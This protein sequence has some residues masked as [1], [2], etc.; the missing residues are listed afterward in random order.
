M[1]KTIRN[2]AAL[3]V[4]AA[5]LLVAGTAAAYT[6]FTSVNNVCPTCTQ[7]KADVLTTNDGATIRGSVLA[8]NSSFYVFF[9][10][11]E[12]R[13]IPKNEVQKIEWANGTKPGGL[14]NF[15]QI[16][17]KS[18]HVM[19]GTIVDNKEKP[20][21][22]QIKSSKGELTYVVFKSQVAKIF[23]SGSESSL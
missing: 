16:V 10:Y 13:A 7:P 18:G 17:L 19:S 6:P 9:R 11:G 5:T 4:F 20:A 14:T 2:T 23:K 22:F 15:D 1:V 12:I 8:E 21:L 3:V